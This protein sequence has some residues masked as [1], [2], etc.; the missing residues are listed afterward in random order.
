MG[1]HKVVPVVKV[2]KVGSSVLL[3]SNKSISYIDR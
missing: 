2:V 3:N 1:V